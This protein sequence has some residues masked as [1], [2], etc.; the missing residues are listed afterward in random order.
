MT[1]ARHGPPRAGHGTGPIRSRAIVACAPVLPGTRFIDG[2]PMKLR[3]EDVGRPVIDL[4]RR[5]DLLDAAV[6]HDDDAVGQRHR[7]DLVVGHEDDRG[8]EF[9]CSRLI[10]VRI[11]ARSWAS[12]LESGSSNRKTAGLRT[13]AR[14]MA[15]R[16]RWPPESCGGR[17]SSSSSGRA[18]PP[19]RGCAC[20]SRPCRAL[21][22][23]ARS[24]C[25]G[26]RHVRVERVV[27]EHHGDVPILG[28]EVV[29]DPAADR[30]LA[31]R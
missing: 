17:R 14:P 9:W 28:L 24:R 26:H 18:S 12:R 16:W 15:T 30:D 23:A 4:G 6:A 1:G 21:R 10:S 2:L 5:A 11:W 19:P 13:M 3:D 22:R 7:L 27:L 8:A 29:D 25:S 20:P 31:R